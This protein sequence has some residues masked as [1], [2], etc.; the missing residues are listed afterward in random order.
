MNKLNETW[1]KVNDTFEPMKV[2]LLWFLAGL[3]GFMGLR[4]L[5]TID[6]E[7]MFEIEENVAMLLAN[8]YLIICLLFLILSFCVRG[9]S[10]G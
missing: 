2:Y 9:K 6:S 10:N 3:N 1:D 7:Q 4:S 5:F 8:S